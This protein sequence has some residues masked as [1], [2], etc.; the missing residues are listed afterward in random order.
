MKLIQRYFIFEFLK[1]LSVIALGSSIVFSIVGFVDRMAS[2]MAHNPPN[3]LL[4]KYILFS[5]PKY[6]YYLL[7]MSVLFSALIVFSR[8]VNTFE[9]TAIRSAGGN[10]KA[11]LKPFF[12]IGLILTILGFLIGEVVSPNSNKKIHAIRDNIINKKKTITMKE[13]VLYMRGKDGSIIRISLYL[14]EIKTCKGIT[15]FSLKDG[16]LH[17]RIDAKEAIWQENSWLLKDV[18]INDVQNSRFTTLKEMSLTNIDSPNIFQEE[19]W[20][21]EELTLKELIDFRSRLNSAGFKNMRLDVDISSRIIYSS[22]NFIMLMLGIS[23]PL[24]GSSL[25]L[26][27]LSISQKHSNAITAGIGVV[28]SV[29]YWL[30]YTLSLSLG[31]AGALPPFLAPLIMPTFFLA[32]SLTLFRHIKE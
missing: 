25:Y 29:F 13:G 11:L 10:I 23:L 5:V 4:L 2:L 17:Q 32:F 3:Y 21:P 7:P 14:P 31:Y 18:F 8:A 1:T 6:I 15:I 26:K 24:C 16:L 30:G 9:I 22:I 27:I 20:T 12:V 28:I 19:M